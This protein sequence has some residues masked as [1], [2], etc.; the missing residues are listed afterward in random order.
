MKLLI[1]G[2]GGREHALAWK[3]SQSPKVE[4]IWVAPGNAGTAHEPK[5]QNAPISATDIPALLN[6]A[7][8]HSIDMTVVGP[9]APLSLG[10]VNHFQQAGL[11]CF[12]PTQQAARLESSKA[13]SKAFMQRHGIPTAQFASFTDTKAALAYLKTRRVPIVIKADGLAAGKG[14]VIAHS[15]AEAEQAIKAMLEEQA[16]G[17]AGLEIVIEDYLI[18]EEASFIVITD[19]NTIRPL[20]T[21]QDH[22]ARDNGD[23]G[24]N[25]GGMGAYSPA[26]VVTKVIH[27]TVMETIVKPTIEGMAADGHPYQ[28][29]LYVGLMITPD[30]TPNVLEYNCRLGDPETQPLMLRLNTDLVTLCQATLN[31]Q[32]AKQPAIEWHPNPALG[33]VLTAKGYPGDYAKGQTIEG[34]TLNPT[35]QTST[36]PTRQKIFIAGAIEQDGRI[37]TNGGRVLCVTALGDTIAAAQQNAYQLAKTVRWEGAYYRTDIGHRAI[38][39]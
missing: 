36:S 9:E 27:H 11:A 38:V 12:G 21:S 6:F 3:A 13:F 22:K 28:G 19:G 34:L 29:F 31:G 15:Q 30:G 5:V 24:P 33:V 18:G 32:L 7:K 4:Q 14:V 20:S 8:Q 17:N 25:T 1:I 16:F 2:S 26:P 37:V 23:K 39:D 10:I 35:P